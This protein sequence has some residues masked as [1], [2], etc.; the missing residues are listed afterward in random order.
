MRGPAPA[1]RRL[2]EPLELRVVVGLPPARAGWGQRVA[3]GIATE[4]SAATRLITFSVLLSK[5]WFPAQIARCCQ[6]QLPTRS[7][8]NGSAPDQKRLMLRVGVF[9]LCALPTRSDPLRIVL[10]RACLCGRGACADCTL[11]SGALIRTHPTE[12]LVAAAAA[13]AAAA[14][15]SREASGRT[16]LARFGIGGGGGGGGVKS[17]CSC[18]QAGAEMEQH[19]SLW[20]RNRFSVPDGG[21]VVQE[22]G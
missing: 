5:Y 10:I 20:N 3:I 8:R 1:N 15:R 2:N 17:R 12:W 19:C 21:C 4:R 22:Q 16:A 18:S 14:A 13:A 7:E 11:Q 6:S 9:C